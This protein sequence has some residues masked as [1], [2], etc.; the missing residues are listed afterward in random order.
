MEKLILG[1]F[2]PGEELDIVDNQE[3]HLLIVFF[4]LIDLLIF[5]RIDQ[6]GGKAF[7]IDVFDPF[8]RGAFYNFI[9]DGLE[10]MSFSETYAAIDEERVIG[11]PQVLVDGVT[12]GSRP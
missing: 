6:L 5:N 3:I 2:P 1:L 8:L 7:R 10:E 4:E 12:G 11:E 9:A